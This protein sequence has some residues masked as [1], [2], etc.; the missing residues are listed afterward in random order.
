MGGEVRLFRFRPVGVFRPIV[1]VED[2]GKQG[3][4]AQGQQEQ[5]D[6]PSHEGA[7]GASPSLLGCSFPAFRGEPK[8]AAISARTAAAISASEST[9][10]VGFLRGR[11]G[12]EDCWGEGP[13][14]SDAG[15]PT[16][17]SSSEP[18][19]WLCGS[20]EGPSGGG[21]SLLLPEEWPGDG[22]SAADARRGSPQSATDGAPSPDAG[23][24]SG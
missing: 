12:G 4:G 21:R 6:P 13:L 10:Q 23:P 11:S 7:G 19:P 24:G 17:G 14:S 9:T 15:I 16:P 22:A 5:A 18:L 8:S 2:I 1:D 3:D 20:E